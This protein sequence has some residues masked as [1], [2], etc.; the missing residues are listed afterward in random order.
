ME[1]TH[2]INENCGHPLRPKRISIQARP[3][4]RAHAGKGRCNVC[5]DREYRAR[6]KAE[7]ELDGVDV[8]PEFDLKQAQST[9]VGYIIARRKRRGE[10]L[11]APL[12]GVKA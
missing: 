2:C 3:G 8:K 9:L 4:T 6:K 12:D 1:Y 11:D 10:P 7:A 5:A